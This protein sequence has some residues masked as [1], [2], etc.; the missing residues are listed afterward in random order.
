MKKVR[1]SFSKTVKSV[2]GTSDSM[3]LPELGS[4]SDAASGT[5]LVADEKQT[6]VYLLKMAQEVFKHHKSTEYLMSDTPENR[7]FA[8]KVLQW[9]N[10]PTLQLQVQGKSIWLHDWLLFGY[11]ADLFAGKIKHP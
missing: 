7:E 2:T 9:K 3:L 8:A 10:D 4:L 1:R 6:L 11:F 5:S